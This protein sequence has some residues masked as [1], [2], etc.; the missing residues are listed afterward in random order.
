MVLS[1]GQDGSPRWWLHQAAKG[2]TRTCGWV[3]KR[4]R[5][6]WN[7]N[8]GGPEKKDKEA[9]GRRKGGRGLVCEADRARRERR[10]PR[11]SNVLGVWVGMT[12]VRTLL[13]SAPV[14]A[15]LPRADQP[16][17][18]GSARIH[19]SARPGSPVPKGAASQ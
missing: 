8:P 3:E 13:F 6:I 11:T 5:A 12:T 2:L 14:S 1:R 9:R 7:R 10:R 16:G 15:R 17:R 18:F 19:R 4:K